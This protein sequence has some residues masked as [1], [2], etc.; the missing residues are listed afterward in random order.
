[1]Y[2]FAPFLPTDPKQGSLV[3]YVLIILSISIRK[4]VGRNHISLLPFLEGPTIFSERMSLL[5]IR[6]SQIDVR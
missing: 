1:M 2:V 6:R 3:G 4:L 5:S